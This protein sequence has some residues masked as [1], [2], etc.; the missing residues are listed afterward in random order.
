[1]INTLLGMSLASGAVLALCLAAGR[2]LGN[3]LPARWS[4]RM[5]KAAL[6]FL[7]VHKFD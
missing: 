7:L 2:L 6:C 3:R 4:Y 5:L 1:M